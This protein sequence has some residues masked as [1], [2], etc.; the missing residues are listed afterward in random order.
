MLIS[1]KY[2][3]RSAFF[4]KF[5]VLLQLIATMAFK[6]LIYATALQKTINYN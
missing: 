2:Q 3:H 5:S 1:I 4:K 6:L